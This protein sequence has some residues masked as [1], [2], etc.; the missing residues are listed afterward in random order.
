[1]KVLEENDY[2][3]LPLCQIVSSF[4]VSADLIVKLGEFVCYLSSRRYHKD[5]NE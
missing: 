3:E 1:M 2:F 5:M 4:K